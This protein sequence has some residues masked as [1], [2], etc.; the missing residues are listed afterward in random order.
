MDFI[1]SK[2]G[3]VTS[4]I[5]LSCPAR[6]SPKPTTQWFKDGVQIHQQMSGRVSVLLLVLMYNYIG[7]IS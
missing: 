7:I 3:Q 2:I 4:Y 6:G 5:E 1:R